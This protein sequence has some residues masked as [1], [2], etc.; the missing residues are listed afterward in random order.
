M[1]NLEITLH[2]FTRCLKEEFQWFEIGKIIKELCGDSVN[3][4]HLGG[5]LVLF[6]SR[7]QDKLKLEDLEG[8]LEWFEFIRPWSKDD[9]SNMRVVWTK[10]FGVPLHAWKP[11]FLILWQ[12]NLGKV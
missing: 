1:K 6:R 3:V 7:N 4:S 10:W 8:F 9:I 2:C 12:L 11:K 5:E